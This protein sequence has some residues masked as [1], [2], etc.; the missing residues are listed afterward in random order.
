MS[1]I[2]TIDDYK[3]KEADILGKGFLILT[4][5]KILINVCFV[6]TIKNNDIK[7]KDSLCCSYVV[8]T[9]LFVLLICLLSLIEMND[10]SILLLVN[11]LFFYFGDF[12]FRIALEYRNYN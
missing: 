10:Y 1:K 7:L 9:L 4:F 12:A 11:N 2:K 8:Q 5:F 3:D 6:V